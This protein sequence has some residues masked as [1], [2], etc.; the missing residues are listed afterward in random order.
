MPSFWTAIFSRTSCFTRQRIHLIINL[1][2][3]L[4]HD[5]APWQRSWC[6][7]TI[8][9]LLSRGS[10]GQAASE[11]QASGGAGPWGRAASQTP[12]SSGPPEIN[13]ALS[14]PGAQ[15]DDVNFGCEIVTPF[16]FD[17]V[18]GHL[19]A[20]KEGHYLISSVRRRNR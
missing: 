10:V 18:S 15:V 5:A 19:C 8:G 1:R 7:Q 2:G 4:S 17:I 6:R 16:T 13:L 12:F 14:L 20:I 3:R 11:V 9:S